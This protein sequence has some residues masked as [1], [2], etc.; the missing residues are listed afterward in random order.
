[1]ISFNRCHLSRN[2][3]GPLEDPSRGTLGNVNYKSQ[4]K[5]IIKR[6]IRLTQENVIHKKVAGKR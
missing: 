3:C 2:R 6:M 4:Y 5:V 1:M